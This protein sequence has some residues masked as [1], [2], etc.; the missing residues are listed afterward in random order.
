M[1]GRVGLGP[2][3]LGWVDRA[4]LPMARTQELVFLRV[5]EIF[6]KNLGRIKYPSITPQSQWIRQQPNKALI[7]EFGQ[8]RNIRVLKP[9]LVQT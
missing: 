7:S 9:G 3:I 5:L 2:K 6:L 8:T 4:G 1:H